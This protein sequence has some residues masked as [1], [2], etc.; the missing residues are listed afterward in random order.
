[1]S[2]VEEPFDLRGLAKHVAK[3]DK[4]IED[5]KIEAVAGISDVQDA[6]SLKV[7]V[8][9]Q[10][11]TKGIKCSKILKTLLESALIKS[12]CFVQLFHNPVAKALNVQGI[13]VTAVT[14]EDPAEEDDH[15]HVYEIVPDTE[16]EIVKIVSHERIRWMSKQSNQEQLGG[17]VEQEKK[18]KNVLINKRRIGLRGILISGPSGCGKTTLIEKVVA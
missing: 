2:V 3:L 1:M 17:L 9:V 10:D 6:S 8:I 14:T 5:E 7:I 13:F 18:L 11:V 15:D 12:G 16:I 4:N